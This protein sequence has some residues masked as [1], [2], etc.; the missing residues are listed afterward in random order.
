MV[1]DDR[2]DEYDSRVWAATHVLV[3]RARE[4]VPVSGTA[5]R[6]GPYA[7]WEYIEPPVPAW[8]AKRACVLG[9]ESTGTTMLARLSILGGVFDNF[10]EADHQKQQ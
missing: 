10:R 9:A 5:V 2:Y 7:N 8:Y 4:R 1:I 6:S 3:D